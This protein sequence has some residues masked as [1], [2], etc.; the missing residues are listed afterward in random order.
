MIS[1]LFRLVFLSVLAA[2][3]AADCTVYRKLADNTCAETCLGASTGICPSSVIVKYGGLDEGSCAK[4]GYTQPQGEIEQNAGPCGTLK[5]EKFSKPATLLRASSDSSIILALSHINDITMDSIESESIPLIDEDCKW[6]IGSLG[7]ANDDYCSFQFRFGD[8]SLDQACRLRS[9]EN[10][11]CPAVQ[12]VD[13]LDAAEYFNGRWFEIATCDNFRTRFEK[14]LICISADYSFNKCV[15]NPVVVTNNGLKADGSASTA[16]AKARQGNS[17][18][19]FEV[20]FFGPFFAPYWVIHVESS[21]EDEYAVAI[22]YSCS[23]A[24]QT[25]WFLSRTPELPSNSTYEELM[26]IAR[27]KGIDVDALGVSPSNQQ[28]GNCDYPTPES[29]NPRPENDDECT[30]GLTGCKPSSWC[31]FQFHWGDYTP[32]QSC[33][34]KPTEC[35]EAAPLEEDI[36]EEQITMILAQDPSKDS[37]TARNAGYSLSPLMI[38]IGAAVVGAVAIGG[39]TVIVLRRRRTQRVAK[40]IP[41]MYTRC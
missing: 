19:K 39:F 35:D 12:T 10:S 6:S 22:V 1:S 2:C 25:V 8:L 28:D 31:S 24:G 27:E 4:I 32:S 17:G 33:R 36:D 41:D 23:K 20:S 5:F 21:D 34:V 29:L 26:D 9:A 30:F 3:A 18:G 11:H 13:D 37:Q 40:V 14:D 16:I 7:C 38:A 15:R